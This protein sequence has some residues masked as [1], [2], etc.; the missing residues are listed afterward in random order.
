MRINS[1]LSCEKRKGKVEY[2]KIFK[3]MIKLPEKILRKS[4]IFT[5]KVR[6]QNG[7]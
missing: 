2:Q 3:K 1:M 4:T 5:I 6:G 7:I